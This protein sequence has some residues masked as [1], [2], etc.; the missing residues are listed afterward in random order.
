MYEAFYGFHAKPFSLLPDPRFMYPS[1]QHRMALDVL[2]CGLMNR[3]GIVVVTGEAGSGKTTVVRQLLREMDRSL[4]I[5][6]LANTYPG[7]GS[8]LPWVLEAY[9][10]QYDGS[11]AAQQYHALVEFLL[12]QYAQGRHGVLIVDEAQNLDDA[13]LEQLRVLSNIN[14]DQDQ[15]LQL[16]LVGQPELRETLQQPRHRAFAQRVGAEY[17]IEPL[18]MGEVQVYIRHRL[19]CAGGDPELFDAAACKLIAYRSGGIPRLINTLCDTALVYG[20]AEQA[21]RIDAGIVRDLV[22]DKTRNGIVPLLSNPVDSLE[23]AAQL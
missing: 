18:A 6:L 15:V 21:A 22:R 4:V 1:D 5:G 3:L 17:H 8:L 19:A 13:M 11:N 10:L 14:A 7:M 23:P 2:E 9:Q 12:A 20:F 16:I